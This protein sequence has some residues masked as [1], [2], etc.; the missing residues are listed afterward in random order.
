MVPVWQCAVA[1][2]LPLQACITAQ[3]CLCA[4]APH[5]HFCCGTAAGSPSPWLQQQPR[6]V[7]ASVLA[8]ASPVSACCTAC[9]RPLLLLLDLMPLQDVLMPLLLLF[10]RLHW[11]P[12]AALVLLL[13]L[14]LRFS[15]WQ[16]PSCTRD[17]R[18]CC[19]CCSSLCCCSTASTPETGSPI[20]W[21][22]RLSPAQLLLTCAPAVSTPAHQKFD[23]NPM[24]TV[25]QLKTSHSSSGSN[26]LH[27]VLAIGYQRLRPTA[28]H[29]LH[30]VANTHSKLLTR[31]WCCGS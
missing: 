19:C 8:A 27:V 21:Q 10:R 12:A 20:S 15:T 9:M 16:W 25:V 22:H 7:S 1:P 18:C 31:S 14:L 28:I 6:P 5:A 23:C 17:G 2:T 4:A 13:L 29:K 30:P 24:Y 26:Q 11:W 3:W